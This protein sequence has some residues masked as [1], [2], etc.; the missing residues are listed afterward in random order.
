LDAKFNGLGFSN[1]HPQLGLP[2][3]K[4]YLKDFDYGNQDFSGDPGQDN[5]LTQAWL[6]SSLKISA[7]EQL[8]FMQSMLKRKFSLSKQAVKNTEA[9]MYI[10]TSP[11]GWRLYGKTG[12]G[13]GSQPDSNK[14]FSY[15]DG[16]FVGFIKNDEQ[17]YIIVTNF[18]APDDS[19]DNISPG[20]QAKN[21]S[22][23]ILTKMGL[24]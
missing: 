13:R 21:I 10:E 5:A 2:T 14:A 22:I 1:T 18:T 4:K 20:I 12:S 15:E 19:D 9:N 8:K 24:Y 17:T 11:L 16:W 3:I 23:D 6:S 7:L